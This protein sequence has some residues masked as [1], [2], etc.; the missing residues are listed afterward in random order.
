MAVDRTPVSKRCK[1]L[2]ISPAILG[3]TDKKETKRHARPNMRKKVS[4]YGL[5]LKEKQKLKF[6]YGV[7]ERQFYHYYELAVK[8][9]GV[10]GEN[11]LEL[12]E[13][14]LDNVVFRMGAA[15][16]RREARQ[17]VNH[18]HFTVNG[19]RVDIPSYRVKA[20]DVVAVCD[21][22]KKSEKFKLVRD[23]VHGRL[24]PLWITADT[25]N[26]KATVERLPKREELDYEIA[27]HLVIELYS[28]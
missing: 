21:K 22:S 19:S 28:K 13:S 17:L 1:S 14:R 8:R 18:G 26:L 12:L 24:I 20:G 27:E 16:T 11:L 7:L 2:G 3:Y 9:H 10:T 5:Q 15:I 4:E 25:E 6:I 23:A